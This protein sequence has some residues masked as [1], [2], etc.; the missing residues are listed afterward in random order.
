MGA[1]RI[2]I[3]HQQPEP[4]TSEWTCCCGGAA[5]VRGSA[6]A[7]GMGCCEQRLLGLL[8]VV[9]VENTASQLISG[10]TAQHAVHSCSDAMQRRVRRRAPGSR[11]EPHA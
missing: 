10:R 1:G 2:L 3:C 4:S 5:V 6:T 11:A 9:L 7:A 8:G